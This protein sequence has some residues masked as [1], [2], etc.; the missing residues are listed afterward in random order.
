MIKKEGKSGT[1]AGVKQES[2]S[3]RNMIGMKRERI[4]GTEHNL[5]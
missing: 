5:K 2:V 4:M 3:G 1:V